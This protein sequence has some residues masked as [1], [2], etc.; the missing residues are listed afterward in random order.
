VK[1]GNGIRA[2]SRVNDKVGF[3]SSNGLLM[4]SINIT[5]V[6][7]MKETRKEYRCFN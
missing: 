4:L 3:S 5:N 2:V 6:C 7:E 1:R